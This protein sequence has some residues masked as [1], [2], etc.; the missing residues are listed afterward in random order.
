MNCA[1]CGQA[2]PD[3]AIY[4]PHCAGERQVGECD[5]IRAGLKAGGLALAVGLVPSVALLGIYGAE[6]GIKALAFIIPVVFFTTG[7]IIGMVKAKWK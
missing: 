3:D 1:K 7:L 4:C 5:I 6:R 2:V